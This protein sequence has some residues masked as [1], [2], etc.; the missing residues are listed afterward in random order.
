MKVVA[1][2][3]A[4]DPRPADLYLLMAE[5]GFAGLDALNAPA[6][7]A[8]YHARCAAEL[9]RPG[10]PFVPVSGTYALD[11]L[12]DAFAFLDLAG[13]PVSWR[14]HDPTVRGPVR[15]GVVTT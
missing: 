6:E 14:D 7:R 12:L 8:V 10:R 11:A 4:A 1:R 15:L 3:G 5:R 9:T 13:T 2:Y